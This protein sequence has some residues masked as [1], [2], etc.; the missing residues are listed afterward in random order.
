MNNL[1]KVRNSKFGS[2][3][4]DYYGDNGGE[5]FMTRQQIGEALGYDNPMIAIA[6]IHDR[7][8]DRIDKFSVLTK[9]TGTDGKRYETYLYS[10]KGV[11]EICRW[12]RQLAADAFYDHVYD[13]LEGL[14]LGYLRLSLERQSSHW[15]ATRLESKTNRR[16]KTDEI[17]ALVEYA[18]T[19][20]SK[21]A[22]KY[23]VNFTKLAN[24][25]VGIPPD[26]RDA[27]TTNQLNNL[28]LI[29]HIIGEIIKSGIRTGSYY[30]DIYQACKKQLE[31]FTTIAF[32]K[33]G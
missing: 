2:I 31:Q 3:M 30:K 28:I 20:G 19:N 17:K 32:L 14:R 12:S 9:L 13:I 10:A 23:Y 27:I 29:E 21:N 16:L 15:Q 8:K 5:F 11:Y 24:K 1:V 26:S 6:K 22:D 25:V 7:H 18:K 4:C 33:A